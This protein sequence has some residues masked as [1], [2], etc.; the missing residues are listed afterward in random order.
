MKYIIGA[1]LI[2]TLIFFLIALFLNGIG[3]I[4]S[5]SILQYG[6]I[7]WVVLTVLCYPLAKK[8]MA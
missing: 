1:V 6:W 5:Q 3:F 8:I 2:S 4:P 7:F